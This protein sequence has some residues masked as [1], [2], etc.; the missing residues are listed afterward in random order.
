MKLL[1]AAFLTLA[2]VFFFAPD[3]LADEAKWDTLRNRLKADGFSS[4]HIDAVFAQESLRYDPKIMARKMNALLK[5]KLSQ[6]RKGGPIAPAVIERHLNPVLI[7]GAYAFYKDKGDEMAE[8]VAKYG[9]PAEILTALLLVETKLGMQLGKHKAL[10]I[11]SNM[12]IGGDFEVIRPHIEM[13][14]VSEEVSAWLV[15]RTRQKG[16]WAYAELKALLQYAE[17]SRRD[18]LTIPS[19]MYGAIGMCQFIPTSAVH[20]GVDGD[21]DGRVDLFNTVD[22]LHSTANFVKR[23]GWK[24]DLDREGQLKVI[25]RYNHSRS[26]ALTILAVADKLRKTIQLFGG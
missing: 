23:H 16:E 9:V 11:L 3:A 19:S 26:Y 14:G 22:A 20:Y 6:K 18:P 24:T 17:A 15:K 13:D 1:A 7:A 8:V 5:T 10:E 2:A 4:V 12:T 25:Y 21:G